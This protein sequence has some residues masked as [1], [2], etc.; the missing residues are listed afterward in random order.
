MSVMTVYNSSVGAS[1]KEWTVPISLRD[2]TVPDSRMSVGLTY[3]GSNGALT[4]NYEVSMFE[5]SDFYSMSTAV[6]SG[7]AVTGSFTVENATSADPCV[8]SGTH[9]LSTDDYVMLPDMGND[10]DWRKLGGDVF[11][12]TS[13]DASNIS[14]NGLDASSYGAYD[15]TVSGTAY[16]VYHN[17]TNLDPVD[18]PYIRFKLTETTGNAITNAKLVLMVQ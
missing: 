8:I 13:V 7:T 10:A 2:L 4:L 5:E 1:S 14:L 17:L 18:A 12:V 15:S 9:G 3:Y 16:K 11:Q 6:I